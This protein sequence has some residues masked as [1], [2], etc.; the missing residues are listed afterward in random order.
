MTA[1]YSCDWFE[2]FCGMACNSP[3]HSFVSNQLLRHPLGDVSL[4]LR[5][6]GTR[7]YAKVWCVSVRG[8]QPDEW[9]E[10]GT[11]C[12]EP[13]SKK[14]AG[15]IMADYNCHFKL[16]NYW[17]YCPATSSD[18]LKHVSGLLCIK[19]IRAS[20]MDFCCD[21]QY[22]QN[23]LYAAD[24]MR[25]IVNRKYV[26]VHQPKWAM[27]GIDT[28]AKLWINSLSFG[29]KQSAVFTRFYNKS[30]E[31]KESGKV[32]IAE[33]WQHVGFKE[34][35]DIYRV[36]FSLHDCGIKSVDKA[37]GAIIEVDWEQ[38]LN[39]AYIANM[40]LYYAAYYFDIRQH[41][42]PRKYR[43]TPLELFPP[44][45]GDLAV[46]QNPR[47][48]VSTR[49]SRLVANYLREH[50]PELLDNSADIQGLL[51][52]MYRLLFDQRLLNIY[53]YERNNTRED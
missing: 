18:L 20:R 45:A 43:C 16:A 12:C 11:L 19:P 44:S 1:M 24:L 31:L 4:T 13:L 42:N 52:S 26:K 41:D 33:A 39:L 10:F 17:C 50:A 9:V 6:Y 7:V 32:Y 15:G 53:T 28:D 30:L 5:P 36:E 51:G 38:C 34:G 25:G 8:S 22:A 35:V 27:H 21:F 49:T 3:C 14:S 46:W 29:S 47:H 37:T 2:I 48:A 23:G 40:W